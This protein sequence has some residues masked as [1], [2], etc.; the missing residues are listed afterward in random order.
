MGTNT[1]AREPGR[2]T[3]S[4]VHVGSLSAFSKTLKL[5][6]LNSTVTMSG[7][8]EQEQSPSEPSEFQGRVDSQHTSQ[9]TEEETVAIS[10]ASL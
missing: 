5:T 7:Q 4:Q 2:G 6:L 10:A 8:K 1:G 9:A 3:W